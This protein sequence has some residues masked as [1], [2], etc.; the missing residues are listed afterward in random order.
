MTFI[1]YADYNGVTTKTVY[2]IIEREAI[3]N[4][5]DRLL[6]VAM[7][8]TVRSLVKKMKLVHQKEKIHS[9]NKTKIIFNPLF[10]I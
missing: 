5:A 9:K 3:R 1:I 7:Q 4:E 2:E 6:A 10:N 8:N